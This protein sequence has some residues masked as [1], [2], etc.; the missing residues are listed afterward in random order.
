MYELK[1]K[2]S[3]HLTSLHLRNDSVV[4]WT[5][6]INDD[7]FSTIPLLARGQRLFCS[8]SEKLAFLTFCHWPG[9]TIEP[10]LCNSHMREASNPEE[11]LLLVD[12]E[13]FS[14]IK[15]SVLQKQT[16]S[17]NS[18]N[19]YFHL[20]TSEFMS[21]IHI[22]FIK[23]RLFPYHF[24]HSQR[25][26]SYLST[27]LLAALVPSDM[28]RQPFHDTPQ[29]EVTQLLQTCFSFLFSPRAILQL[30]GGST[31][32]TRGTELL[33]CFCKVNAYT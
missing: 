4:L 28:P 21:P 7:K 1:S 24:K 29:G 11:Q 12:I 22:T 23:S 8:F 33:H 27:K 13:I 14:W 20:Q 3:E 10:Q 6:E 2:Q 32:P 18:A 26:L 17:N 30:K 16:F 31:T 5:N 9:M 15:T 25:C 19:A